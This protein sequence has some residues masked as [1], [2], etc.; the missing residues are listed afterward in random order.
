MAN[1]SS[2]KK[3]IRQIE[4]RT[5]VNKSRTSKIRT[6]IKKAL[7]SITGQETKDIA[8]LAVKKAQSEIARGVKAGILKKNTAARKVSKLAL[9]LNSKV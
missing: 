8:A 7:E 3:A 5:A 2:A 1:N 6:Y 4:K 9:K